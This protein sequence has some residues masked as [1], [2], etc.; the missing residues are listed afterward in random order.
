MRALV[1]LVVDGSTYESGD[2]FQID[3]YRAGDFVVRGMAEAEP[4]TEAP[5]PRR[6]RSTPA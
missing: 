5:R 6:R 3:A 2:V 4:D 1:T